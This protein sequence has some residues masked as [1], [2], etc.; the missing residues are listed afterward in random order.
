[1]TACN[2]VLEGRI[3][4]M[5]SFDMHARLAA[6]ETE[7]SE[8]GQK[9]S[10]HDGAGRRTMV[11]VLVGVL[12]SCSGSCLFVPQQASFGVPLGLAM[13]P[14]GWRIEKDLPR[15]PAK[16]RFSKNG[17]SSGDESLA[18][19]AF[20]VIGC[21]RPLVSSPFASLGQGLSFRLSSLVFSRR[22]AFAI[23]PD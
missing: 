18:T 3:D 7:T 9:N 5:P 13:P 10:T 22:L 21:C 1:M 15:R 2:K 14:V 20:K 6:S 19:F 16:C 4:D 12:G 17:M 8:E 23:L 11:P